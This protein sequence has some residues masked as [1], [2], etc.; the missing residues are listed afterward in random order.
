MYDPD[1]LAFSIRRPWKTTD[2]YRPSWLDIWHH[3]PEHGGTGN[4]PDDSCGWFE[5]G[6]KEYADAVRYV[7]KD[8]EFVFELQRA[9]D[10]RAPATHHGKYTFP[11]MTAADTLAAVLM[12][13]RYLETRRW[14]NGQNG[15]LG[16][17]HTFWRKTFTRAR[18]VDDL[19]YDLALNP[20]DN[21][22]SIDEPERMVRL[23][24]AALHRR[25]KPW[26]RHP[27]WHVHHWQ[28]R[29]PALQPYWR[30][31]FGKRCAT[32]GGRIG[33]IFKG[34]GWP[35]RDGRGL[36]HGRCIDHHPGAAVPIDFDDIAKGRI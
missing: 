18:N 34:E 2:G 1:T 31:M 15:K 16:V 9:I 30:W 25:F 5:R 22:S 13:A 33:P 14:W 36:H 27:R 24:A 6:P 7:L 4:R 20:L 32:C 8:S 26:W 29:F 12:T 10:R 3:D 17:C 23:V 28:I 19:A 35:V 11:R 21:L